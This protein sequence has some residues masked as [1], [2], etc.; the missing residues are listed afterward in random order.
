MD[1]IYY[2]A[3]SKNYTVALQFARETVFAEK[4]GARND[5][6]KSIIFI[7]DGNADFAENQVTLLQKQNIQVFAVGMV[8]YPN[9]YN[10]LQLTT[11]YAFVFDNASFDTILSIEGS[12]A[13]ATCK[14]E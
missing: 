3:L 12:L 7:T 1:N 6:V 8:E 10:L 9:I 5:S 4:N 2:N 14:S 13:N 11:S